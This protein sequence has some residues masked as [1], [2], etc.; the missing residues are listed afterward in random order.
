[1]LKN[2]AKNANLKYQVDVLPSRTGTD[3]ENMQI[4]GFG[5][6]TGVLSVPLKYMHTPVETVKLEDIDQAG[7]LLA[8]FARSF[9]DEGLEEALCL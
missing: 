4:S 7:R 5:V 2:S 3:A 6:A 1:M 8:E 9:D